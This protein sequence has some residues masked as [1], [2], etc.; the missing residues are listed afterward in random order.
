MGK[1]K[2]IVSDFK[3]MKAEELAS[4]LLFTIFSIFL[5]MIYVIFYIY[6]YIL[7]IFSY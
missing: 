4:C 7:R 3:D 2:N 6:I 1:G 5:F